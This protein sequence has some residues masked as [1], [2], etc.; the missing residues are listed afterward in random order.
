MVLDIT[1]PDL[2]KVIHTASGNADVIEQIVPANGKVPVVTAAT[3]IRLVQ[4]VRE[5]LKNDGQTFAE[6]IGRIADSFLQDRKNRV[7]E[8]FLTAGDTQAIDTNEFSTSTGS[9]EV[10]EFNKATQY[11]MNKNQ[12]DNVLV[13]GTWTALNT[14]TGNDTTLLSDAAKDEYRVNGF[15]R[16]FNGVTLVAVDNFYKGA[17]EVLSNQEI[18]VIPASEQQFVKYFYRPM[19]MGTKDFMES[20]DWKQRYMAYTEDEIMLA[21]SD[22][23]ATYAWS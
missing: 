10:T 11:V 16:L 20:A 1:N 23:Q 15:V 13:L 7:G 19:L 4:G 14:I 9:F 17:T 12:T 5:Y 3:T 2:F 22:Y 8:V 21:S 18:R 6:M